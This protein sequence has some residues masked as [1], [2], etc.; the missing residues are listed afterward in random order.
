MRSQTPTML[1]YKWTVFPMFFSNT[2]SSMNEKIEVN[3]VEQ[4]E[5]GNSQMSSTARENT[6]LHDARKATEEEHALSAKQ[7]LKDYKPAIF[8]SMVMSGTILMEAYDSI[9]ISSLFAYPSFQKRYG[10][11]IS[12]GSYQITGPWQSALGCG[13]SIGIIIALAFNGVLVEKYGHRKIIIVSLFFM[14]AFIFVTVFAKNV[15]MLFVG[16]ILNG[17][18]WGF[19]SVIGLIY[20]SEVAPLPL[21]GFLSAYVMMCWATGQLIAAGVLKAMLNDTTQWAYRLPFAIQWVW[22]PPIFVL[23]LLSPDSPYWLV[24]KGRVEEAEKS[25]KRLSSKSIHP[26]IK[27]K[28]KLLIHTNE[29]EMKQASEFDDRFKGWKSYVECFK[30]PNRRRTEIACM[31]IAGQ[32]LG[33]N[34]FAY[35]PSYFFSQV[36]LNST[37]TYNLNLGITGLAWVGTFVSWFIAGKVGRRKI[38]ITGIFFMT[39]FLLLIGVLQTPA[40][41]NPSVAWAQVGCTFAWVVSFVLTLA[42]LAYTITSEVSSTRLRSQSIAIG[43]NAYNLCQLTAQVVEPYFI[44]PGNLGLKGRTGFIWFGTSFLTL[45]WAIFRLPET[46]DRTYE[47]LDI[48][49]ERKVPLTKFASYKLDINDEN[50]IVSEIK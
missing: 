50:E 36:G 48:L 33:G 11:E 44:N 37:Q 21:R 40:D 45:I 35:S 27:R 24:R 14:A 46:K 47:E 25:L 3:H 28:L 7:A 49:F 30:G 31:S 15:E 16:Q 18:P 23:T 10:K 34:N 38:Y 4:E 12:P 6:I 32:V 43:R 1:C 29:L 5:D 13:S 2:M 26:N 42:P 41:N 22:I 9:L 20:A 8:W 19:F 39:L 17:F